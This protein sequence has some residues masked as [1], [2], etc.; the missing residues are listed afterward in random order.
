MAN[1]QLGF[2]VVGTSNASEVMG[3]AGKEAD[4][5][6]NKLKNAFD[7][8]RTL[9]NAFIGA[10]GLTALLSSGIEYVTSKWDEYKQAQKDAFDA[11]AKPVYDELK[12]QEAL[13]VQLDKNL[14]AI[15]AMSKIKQERA[16]NIEDVKLQEQ[17]AREAFLNSEAGQAFVQKKIAKHGL[18]MGAYTQEELTTAAKAEGA[19]INVEKEKNK[20]NTFDGSISGSLGNAPASGV[21]GVGNNAQLALLDEQLVTLKQIRDG[22]D[23]LG[24]PQG[25]NT[26]FTKESY[27]NIT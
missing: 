19:R 14:S 8:K 18:T 11:G 7:I 12:A 16:K 26:D 10:F 5:L 24:S 6:A 23:A 9:T 13:G 1:Q 3:K 2:D 4:K 15:L 27:Q 17:L 22:I 20:K 21:I 25:M